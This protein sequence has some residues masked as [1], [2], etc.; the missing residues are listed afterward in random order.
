MARYWV[1]VHIPGRPVD[2]IDAKTRKEAA[3]RAR[4]RL[5]D[6]AADYVDINDDKK[7]T[8]DRFMRGE[9]PR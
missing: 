3:E 7:R 2:I 5:T 1:G 9:E 8:T 4:K 6:G